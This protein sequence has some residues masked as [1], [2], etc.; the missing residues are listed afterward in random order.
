M[1][2]TLLLRFLYQT[3]PGRAVLKVLVQPRLSVAAG[4]FLG[5]RLSKPLVP[6]YIKKY[7]IDMRGIEIPERGFSSFNDFFTRK[8]KKQKRNTRLDCLIS[9]CDGLLSVTKIKRD[10][11]FDIKHTK[12]SLEELLQDKSLADE[13]I[14]GTALIFR[15][16]PANYHRYCY[17]ADG[18]I[19]ATRRI[20]GVL[21]CVRPVATKTYP[22]YAQNSREYQTI[23][24]L[25][26]GKMVQMEIGALLVGKI[27]NDA[28]Y[29]DGSIVWAG[30]EKGYFEFGG[31]TILI[32]L[33]EGA[34][35]MNTSLEKQ[36]DK[37]GETEIRMGEV[38]ARQA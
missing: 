5:S 31:S 4:K 11:V 30:D 16:T 2:D 14:N 13:F 19:T 7:H 33:R 21:H 20:E 35:T 25:V 36:K 38:I 26:F 9:L 15:L 22:V 37:N 1:K 18:E 24:S 29:K 28:S 8:R 3:V 10:T 27:T 32:L 34:V 12:F 17:I 6:Y 23:E